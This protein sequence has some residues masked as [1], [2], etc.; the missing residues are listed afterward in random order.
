MDLPDA[1][2]WFV[3]QVDDL[4]EHGGMSCYRQDGNNSYNDVHDGE[5]DA[6]K[7]I[8]EINYITGLY[9]MLDTLR[10]KHPSLIM[11]AAVGAPRIDLETL[12]R[13]HWHQACETWG[14]PE[15]D[16]CTVYGTNFWLPGGMIVLFNESIEDYGAWSRFGGQLTLAWN[17]MDADFPMKE[18][19]RQLDLYK[20]IRLFLSGDFY[21]LTG[22][23]LDETWLGYQ[24]HRFDLHEGVAMIFRRSTSPQTLYSYGAR[25]R[26]QLRGIRPQ[27]MYRVH[28]E[29]TNKDERLTGQAL[30]NG[31]DVVLDKAPSAELILVGIRLTH[32]DPTDCGLPSAFLRSG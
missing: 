8:K 27:S 26:V 16:Q 23:S 22:I 13:F 7:G 1:R 5:I 20:R 14:H 4:I 2:D 17:P 6:R 15:W 29:R 21:P 32:Q 18:A 3:K 31:I 30:A 11:E 10:E 25:L 19:R 12:S 9:T 24:F 28:F